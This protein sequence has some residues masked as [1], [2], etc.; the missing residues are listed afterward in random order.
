MDFN[1]SF[2]LNNMKYTIKVVTLNHIL[3]ELAKKKWNNKLCNE[4]V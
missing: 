4:N 2:E 1:D 3:Y